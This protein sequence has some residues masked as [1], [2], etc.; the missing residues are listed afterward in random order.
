[1]VKA[2]DLKSTTFAFV[3]SS[4][5]AVANF[6]IYGK[7]L[8]KLLDCCFFDYVIRFLSKSGLDISRD[9]N[10]CFGLVN[11]G[12]FDPIQPS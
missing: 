8:K 3:G 2:V 1:M 12:G 6:F 9:L 4:P 11:N 5:T 7:T 10:E